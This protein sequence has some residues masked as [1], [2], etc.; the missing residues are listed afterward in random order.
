[1]KEET[2]VHEVEVNGLRLFGAYGRETNIQDWMAGKDFKI[3]RGPYC[4]I[5][6]VEE[7]V[8]EGFDVLEF[9]SHDGEVIAR[10]IIN[11]YLIELL[12]SGELREH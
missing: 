12:A 3:E 9:C 8:L 6:D 4:S 7:M 2:D 5:R 10:T 1:M 11:P